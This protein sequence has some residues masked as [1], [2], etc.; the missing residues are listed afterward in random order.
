MGWECFTLIYVLLV[1]FILHFLRLFK[2][3][4]YFYMRFCQGRAEEPKT[5]KF[6]KIVTRFLKCRVDTIIWKPKGFDVFFNLQEPAFVEGNEWLA[7]NSRSGALMIKNLLWWAEHW[8]CT[9]FHRIV[10]NVSFCI[11]LP[12]QKGNEDL[13]MSKRKRFRENKTGC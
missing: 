12:T 8:V 13:P 2:Y 6:M 7:W 9:N 3:Q 4:W 11:C 10:K 1:D 5:E